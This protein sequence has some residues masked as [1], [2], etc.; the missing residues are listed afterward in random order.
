MKMFSLPRATRAALAFPLAWIGCA[1]PGTPLPPGGGAPPSATADGT[2]YRLPPREVVDIVDAPATPRVVLSPTGDR[3][4]LARRPPL[5]SIAELA[6][7]ML[8]LAGVRIHPD[9]RERVARVSYTS[10]A[11]ERVLDGRVLKVDLPSEGRYSAP[12]WAPDGSRFLVTRS[13]PEGLEL[14]VVEAE[15]ARARRLTGPI[16]SNTSGPAASWWSGSERI[17]VRTVPRELL[18]PAAPN[19][20]PSGPTVSETAGRQAQNRTYQDLLTGPDDERL[21]EHYFTSELRL[22]SLEGELH[23]LTPPA[24]YTSAQPSPDGR[25]LLVT[26][27]RRPWSYT[28]PYT[29]FAHTVEVWS[30]EGSLVATLADLPVADT[31]PI[32]GVPTG[33]RRHGWR[34]DEPATVVWVEALDG[35]DPKRQVEHRD[36]LLSLAAPFDGTPLELTR[37]AQRLSDVAWTDLP[38]VALVSEYDRDRRWTT[39]TLRNLAV[40]GSRPEPLFDRSI[41][42]AYADPGDPI[43]HTRPDGT[44]TVRVEDGAIYLAGDGASPEGERPFLDRL[45]LSSRETE[46]L[47]HSPADAFTRFLGFTDRRTP[48]GP[49]FL[50]WRESPSEPPNVHAVTPA[51][52]PSRP[53]T[54]FPDPH[55]QLTGIEKRVLHYER[56]DGVPLSGVLYLPPDRREGERLPC[57][58]WA[59]PIEYTDASLAGQVRVTGNRFTRLTGTSPLMLLTQGYAVF[60][61]AAMPVIGDPETMNDTL[62]PQLV[63]SAEAALAALDAT[64]CVDTER[65]AVAGHSYG[66]F[67]TANLLAHSNLFRAGIARSGA[68]N[69]SLTPFGFQSE[70]R[71]LWEATDT[72]IAVSPFFHADEIDEPLLL[73]HGEADN[74]SGT[75]PLQ[76]RR[77]FHALQGL[78]GTARLVML[79]LESHGYRARE[80]VLHVLAETIDWLDRWVRP[81]AQ[82]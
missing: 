19:R 32:G 48:S 73:V 52:G 68:Y 6:E 16:L 34:P 66:A 7:P 69:R 50:V 3:I 62:V 39:T 31:V 80:S 65:V 28:V 64:G 67:M 82:P 63:T 42:D 47:F 54:H 43:E 61:D 77:M 75:Y 4:V 26:R 24:L 38:G 51:G 27:L 2:G 22:V 79:P 76:S 20:I 29:R 40:P 49:E 36:R 11:V 14:W 58:L 56:A 53:L 1:S 15:D 55:P 71:T 74:N 5:A 37:T 17:L 81:V 78:G 21:F 46:R 13:Q 41:H 10:F 25:F 45:H 59:Y 72:Y 33:P 70:R 44:R 8:R 60:D 12:L 9:R 18:A 35:G 57:L 30:V 23:S